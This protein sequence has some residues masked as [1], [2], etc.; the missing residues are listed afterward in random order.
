MKWQ[1]AWHL[2]SPIEPAVPNI[3][4]GN[5][6]RGVD[7]CWSDLAGRPDA[8]RKEVRTPGLD[9]ISYSEK[10]IIPVRRITHT[11]ALLSHDGQTWSGRQSY[12]AKRAYRHWSG[13]MDEREPRGVVPQSSATSK[14]WNPTGTIVGS[15]EGW[16]I[17]TEVVLALLPLYGVPSWAWR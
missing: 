16:R 8:R 9:E 5:T 14:R 13:C 12:E 17:R 15:R 2:L 4:P 1:R 10:D 3:D 7:P 11:A 6:A